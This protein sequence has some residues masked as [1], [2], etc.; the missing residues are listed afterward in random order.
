MPRIYSC[1]CCN[2]RTSRS[3]NWKNHLITDKHIRN[4]NGCPNTGTNNHQQLIDILQ[5]QN[6]MLFKALGKNLQ[7]NDNCNRKVNI[8]NKDF[9]ASLYMKFYYV[10]NYYLLKNYLLLELNLNNHNYFSLKTLL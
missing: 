9:L 6:A 5:Q 1:E 7:S 3:N 10:L 8:S 4:N 2:Y